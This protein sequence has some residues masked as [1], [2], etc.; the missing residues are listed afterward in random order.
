MKDLSVLKSDFA[1]F[2]S[3]IL[4]DIAPYLIT[5]QS[6]LRAENWFYQSADIFMY[7][8][9]EKLFISS[10]SENKNYISYL[11]KNNSFS[12]L[13]T[14][15][16]KTLP[17]EEF[18]I[19]IKGEIFGK[20]H[21]NLMVIEYSGSKKI[22][23][24]AVSLNKVTRIKM[25]QK[26]QN[27]RLALRISNKGIATIEDIY[28]QRIK[29]EIP[30]TYVPN[31]KKISKN[32]PSTISDIKMAC[33]LDEFSMT[34]FGKEV[35]LLTFTTE[36]W[37]EILIEDT[38]DL[39]FVESAWR[40]NFGAW[41]YK[42][43]KYN[44]QDKTPLFDLLRWCKENNIPTVFWNK[45]DP[46]HFEKFIDT[47]KLFDCIFTTDADMIPNYQKESGH[48]RVFALPFSAEPQLHNPIKI[49]EKREE[50]ICFAGSYYDN[51]HEERKQ[52]MDNVL[53]I[54][55]E[56]GLDIF[57][58]NYEKNKNGRTHFSFPERF[59]QNI[60]GSLKYDEIN[61]AY[62]GYKVML[63]VNSVK[64]SPTMFSR[65]V[66][67]GLACGTPIISSYSEGVK[68]MFKDIVLIS[69]N[70]QELKESI[71]KLM[72]DEEY[73][74]EKSLVGIREVYLNHTYKHRIHYM[75]EQLGITVKKDIKN[76]SVLS[77]AKSKVEFFNILDSFKRQSWKGKELIVLLENFDGYVDILNEYNQEN[78]KTY[79]LSYMN[80]YNRI[81]EIIS[82]PYISY[83]NPDSFYGENYLLD[84]MIA[85][86]YSNA[87]II[88]KN[89]FYQYDFQNKEVTKYNQDKE[90]QYVD[91]LQFESSIVDKSI[92][93]GEN[94]IE[95]VTKMRSNSSMALYFMRGFRLLSIDNYNFIRAGVGVSEDIINKI[96]K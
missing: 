24:H 71:E 18:E 53:D 29:Q 12:Y 13:P 22:N 67:E 73:Y 8:Q 92:F 85:T 64:Y 69:E 87:E 21:V 59:D 37:K 31:P 41:E 38:P 62:K 90:Y 56:F 93:H 25:N 89:T 96:Q 66:F 33:I 1:K 70:K 83:F 44:N 48:E 77:V 68:R 42:I 9:K 47:A 28:I 43:A 75:L 35:N 51:R 23:V 82:N 52:D 81:N 3:Q 36:N 40:G 74:N 91:S 58:R 80:H 86:E 94:I 2:Q 65:R 63:N 79:V 46:I 57:D 19:Q 16:L 88:G 78:I 45:E 17:N 54:A 20:A 5:N 84:L 50:K 32:N 4:N 30:N 6:F 61:T 7:N 95:A 76:V 34:C 11:E 39:L 49:R 60:K 14:H 15:D 27:L 72:D 55:A 26:T 10:E